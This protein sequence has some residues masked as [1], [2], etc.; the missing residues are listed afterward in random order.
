MENMNSNAA[1]VIK[2]R[3]LS[4]GFFTINA[5]SKKATTHVNGKIK[6][7]STLERIKNISP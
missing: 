2:K 3:R 6:I 5:A 4:S 1:E 7:N